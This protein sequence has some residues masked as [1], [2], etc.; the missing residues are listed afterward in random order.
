MTTQI[1]FF[2][3]VKSLDVIQEEVNDWLVEADKEGYKVY[4]IQ[5]AESPETEKFDPSTTVMVRYTTQ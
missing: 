4:D 3:S 2:M 5:F 1:K